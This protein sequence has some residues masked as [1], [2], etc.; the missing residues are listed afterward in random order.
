M[1]IDIRPA[2]ALLLALFLAIFCTGCMAD[3][4]EL[5]SL[6]QISEEYVQLQALVSQWIEDG[7]EYAAPVGG[8][9]RQSIQLR[10][11]DGDGVPEAL[12]F[13]ADESH[14]PAVCIY[15][16]DDEGAYYLAIVI[17]GKGAAVDSVEYTDLT[18]DGAAELILTWQ[19][20]GELLLLS[21]YDLSGQEPAELLSADC[22]NFLV[23]DLD[24]DG[25]DELLDL[26]PDSSGDIQLV[27]YEFSE[28]GIPS[29]SA[30]ALST[31]ISEVLRA[32]PAYLS[33]GATALFVDSRTGDD[34]FI[35]DVFTLSAGQLSNITMTAG[36]QSGTARDGD[37]YAEDINA[38]RATEIP[39][40]QGSALAWYGLDSGG[41]MTLALTTYHD[42]DDGWYLILTGLLDGA[43]TASR[44]ESAAG[45]TAVTFTV[46]DEA[47]QAQDILIIYT[48]TGE[49]RLD[50]A[51]AEG[52]F[53][54]RE[55]ETTVYAAALLT[56]ELTQTDITDNFNLIYQQWR[57]GDL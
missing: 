7:G 52:R 32:Q 12:A 2:T 10:D 41:D 30:A 29:S 17:T 5:Y 4:E 14:T 48:L 43:F 28:D 31:G 3:V 26:C 11:L 20:S 22:T 47:G 38:D 42:L 44:Q 9:N 40:S 36:G 51:Q 35:T 24:G 55:E 56:D 13:L 16:Q 23:Y 45:E 33:D 34:A 53:L 19:I 39:L 54:L 1:K 25:T 27:A 46:T 18:G 8:S 49:N 37:V 15:R 21:A 57:A 6:P 50:R